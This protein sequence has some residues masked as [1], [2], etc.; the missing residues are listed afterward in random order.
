M[1]DLPIEQR[2][3]KENRMFHSSGF[4]IA[5]GVVGVAAAGASAAVSMSAADKAAGATA[6]AGKKLEK[7]TAKATDVYQDNIGDAT[8]VFLQQQE[9]LKNAVAAID[10]NISVPDYNLKD[11]TLEGINAAN[12]MTANTLRQMQNITGRNPTEV[13]QNAMNTLGQWESNLQKEYVQVQQG[14]PLI[15]QQEAVVSEMIRGQLPQVTLDQISRTLAERG[16]AGFSMQAAGG[17]PYI[18]SPQAMLAES[19]RQS[20]EA[21]MQQ[22]LALAPGITNQRTA[23]A[24]ATSSLAGASANLS[25][26]MGEWMGV[27]Q[28]FITS[29]AI[30][31]ELSLQGMQLDLQKTQLQMNQLGMISDINTGVYGAQSQL[32]SNLYNAATGQAMTSFDVAQQNTAAQLAQQ[33]ALAS[34]IQSV[35]SATAGALSGVGSAYN[36]LAT[37]NAGKQVTGFGGQQYK[38]INGGSAYAPVSGSIY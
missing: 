32:A 28:G 37:A 29:P 33:Q 22:G 26:V 5:A 27:A 31:M 6:A 15:Q 12:A 24:G 10:P 23:L 7:T 20:S 18:Q 34:G 2:Y 35:G 3:R 4:A 25:N 38:P 1:L 30:P 19:V 17:S 36:Q 9:E 11:A 14:V 8:D 13:I 21:R 16:G